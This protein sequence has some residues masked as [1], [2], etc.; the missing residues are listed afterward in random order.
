M[1]LPWQRRAEAAAARPCARCFCA[2]FEKSLK[3]CAHGVFLCRSTLRPTYSLATAAFPECFL[4]PV[5]F[6]QLRCSLGCC[7]LAALAT[8]V[9]RCK[10]HVPA[11][12]QAAMHAGA[13]HPVVLYKGPGP[14]PAKLHYR[15]ELAAESGLQATE[16]HGVARQW[17]KPQI[18]RCHRR[19]PCA[20]APS[21]CG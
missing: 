1:S 8:S 20:P 12:G 3:H 16:Q 17:G 15:Q 7:Q 2:G 14:A 4:S 9:K 18:S 19:Q 13:L 21:P 11:D 5:S 10:N 6:P